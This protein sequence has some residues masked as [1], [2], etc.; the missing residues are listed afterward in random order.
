MRTNSLGHSVV[1]T[2]PCRYKW[3][4][5]ECPRCYLP[6]STICS[7]HSEVWTPTIKAID[8]VIE[9]LVSTQFH[10]CTILY[11]VCIADIN[12][13]TW[14]SMSVRR[15]LHWRNQQLHMS[16]SDRVSRNTMPTKW[17]IS[18]WTMYRGVWK[19]KRWILPRSYRDPTVIVSP[20]EGQ[21]HF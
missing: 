9:H 19:S 2:D 13:C 16:L 15:N 10:V 5:M 1:V 21:I 17:V 20:S 6:R 12:D 14:N 18:S 3:S 8:K 11:I 4:S 7:I